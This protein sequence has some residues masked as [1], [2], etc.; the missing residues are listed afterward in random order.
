MEQEKFWKFLRQLALVLSSLKPFR[1]FCIESGH[2]RG[3]DLVEDTYLN[4][5]ITFLCLN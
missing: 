3:L 2:I 1:L 5:G 4:N